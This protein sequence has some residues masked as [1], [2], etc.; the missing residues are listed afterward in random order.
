MHSYDVL[1]DPDRYDCCALPLDLR[2]TPLLRPKFMGVVW[3]LDPAAVA[4]PPKIPPILGTFLSCSQSRWPKT[5]I[6]ESVQGFRMG[7]RHFVGARRCGFEIL[8]QPAFSA[9]FAK[10]IIS[11]KMWL[12]GKYCDQ[13][14]VLFE[15]I[16]PIFT[17][18]WSISEPA[19]SISLTRWF[20]RIQSRHTNYASTLMKVCGGRRAVVEFKTG[21]KNYTCGIFAL[22]R[23]RCWKNKF[24]FVKLYHNCNILELYSKFLIQRELSN[25]QTFRFTEFYHPPTLHPVLGIHEFIV[26]DWHFMKYMPKFLK[27]Q[28][29]VASSSPWKWPVVIHF[30]SFQSTGFV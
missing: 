17:W 24:W 25:H 2:R 19:K 12:L 10:S 18:G 27:S 20:E 16:G 9:V 3:R 29:P 21:L 30:E 1:G 6:L 28:P 26:Q 8:K 11:G 4:F 13:H 15:K 5:Y 7:G 23:A 22:V 14:E